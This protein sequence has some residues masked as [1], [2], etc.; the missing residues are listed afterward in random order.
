MRNNT[1]KAGAEKKEKRARVS[2]PIAILS[3]QT[4]Q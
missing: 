4:W 3:A 2:E 1:K